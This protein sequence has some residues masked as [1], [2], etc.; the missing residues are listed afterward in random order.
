MI[1]VHKSQFK[2][3]DEFTIEMP[4][5]ASLLHVAH[6]HDVPRVW[7]LVNTDEPMTKRK[8]RLAGTG[9]SLDKAI[10]AVS[11]YA[12][13]LFL[14]LRLPAPVAALSATFANSHVGSFFQ[15]DGL[16]VWHLFDLGEA[17]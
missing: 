2:I 3:A 13:N 10:S 5:S 14:E 6:Q 1:T 9:H 15:A 4:R 17:R 12:S 8:F 16:L 11:D 7:A